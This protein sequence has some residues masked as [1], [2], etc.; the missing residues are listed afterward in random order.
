MALGREQARGGLHLRGIYALQAAAQF[1][2][3]AIAEAARLQ[4]PHQR[5][6]R[7]HRIAGVDFRSGHARVYA[8][9]LFIADAVAG[10]IGNF[11]FQQLLQL[12]H[13][14]AVGRHGHQRKQSRAAAEHIIACAHIQRRF[15]AAHQIFIEAA[16]A[17][18]AQNIGQ[19]IKRIR[20]RVVEL[21]QSRH[22]IAE[23]EQGLVGHGAG[24]GACRC[25]HLRLGQILALRQRARLNRAE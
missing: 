1:G 17:V 2:L 20:Q 3:I 9:K 12:S 18:A 21:F 25:A 10:N 7:A 16:G 4:L 22:A 14:G 6:L 8:G 11:R 23:R 24:F 19:H 15:F 5:G 13:I